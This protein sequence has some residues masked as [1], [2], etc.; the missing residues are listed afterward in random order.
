MYKKEKIMIFGAI[1]LLIGIIILLVGYNKHTGIEGASTALVN[2]VPPGTRLTI[3]GLLI[4]VVGVFISIYGFGLLPEET[5]R[6]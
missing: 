6:Q 4:A 2:G 3:V 5:K 1:V